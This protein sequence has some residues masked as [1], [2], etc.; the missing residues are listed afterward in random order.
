[1]NNKLYD[2]L[3]S[4][5]KIILPAAGSAYFALSGIWGF[6]LAGEVVGTISAVCLFLG[7]V[8]QIARNGWVADAEL[9]LDVSQEDT[10]SFGFS[11]GLKVE[12]MK[13]GEVLTL[14]V[15]HV[16]G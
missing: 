15:K 11:N 9:L 2:V 7:I 12:E 4:L 6:P 10:T 1:M 5:V 8:I 14:T 3:N 16:D 13:D